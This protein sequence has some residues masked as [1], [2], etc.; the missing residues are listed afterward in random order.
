MNHP[1]NTNGVMNG[2]IWRECNVAEMPI[3]YS[4]LHSDEEGVSS[5]DPE[6]YSHNPR[7][8]FTLEHLNGLV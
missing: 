7:D 3:R 1:R 5:L 8:Y 2:R 6:I 4:H